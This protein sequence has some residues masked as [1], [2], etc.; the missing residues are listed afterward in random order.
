MLHGVTSFHEDATATWG[1]S[2][3]SSVIPTARNMARAPA[4]W[5]PSVTSLDRTFTSLSMTGEGRRANRRRA[6]AYAAPMATGRDDDVSWPRATGRAY[7]ELVGVC[8]LA[9]AEPVLASFR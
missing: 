6:H 8:G 7:V 4:R 9:I 1:F 2:Q 3:S 5:L